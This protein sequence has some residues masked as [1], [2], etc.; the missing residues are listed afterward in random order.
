MSDKVKTSAQLWDKLAHDVNVLETRVGEL[1]NTL[2]QVAM[3]L[4]K[5]SKEHM[6]AAQL[7]Q[8]TEHFLFSLIR[9]GIDSGLDFAALQEAMENYNKHEDLLVYWGIRSQEEYETLKAQ[10]IAAQQAA[11]AVADEHSTA[12]EASDGA[13]TPEM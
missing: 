13:E 1:E 5:L 9:V 11:Q 8:R 2:G 10:A 7:L 12:A 4:D 3:F 6:T